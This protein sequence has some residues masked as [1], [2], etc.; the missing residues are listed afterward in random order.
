MGSN[1]NN[2]GPVGVAAPSPAPSTA[3]VTYNRP[4]S[5]LEDAANYNIRH[6]LQSKWT[7]WYRASSKSAG[8]GSGAAAKSSAKA[9]T[10]EA[11]LQCV[12]TV[13]TIEDFWGMYNNVPG[14]SRMEEN[15]D[16]MFFKEG[17]RPAW[18]DPANASGGSFT[19][20]FKGA[21]CGEF[22]WL[23]TLMLAVGSV[24]T[25]CD[26]VT[27]VFFARR[28]G[29][30]DRISLWLSSSDRE[31][32][33]QVETEWLGAL[34]EVNSEQ[35]NWGNVSFTLHKSGGHGGGER[36]RE[37]GNAN[38]SGGGY[39]SH[40]SRDNRG[41]ADGSVRRS[42]SEY[43]P[44]EGG[45]GRYSSGGGSN[46]GTGGPGGSGATGGS[47]SA[48]Y[49]SA[50]SSGAPSSRSGLRPSASADRPCSRQ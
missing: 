49:S 33:K 23:N 24:L 17:I 1:E 30:P 48:K 4:V 20:Q 7:L 9:D 36:Q 38:A 2:A 32:C 19:L 11:S 5:A 6:P 12:N 45:G 46:R 21:A 18:E 47:S 3:A 16:Y 13:D 26:K 44:R 14:I 42:G 40:G 27:G 35:L 31:L 50:S 25:H 29:R 39:S 43:Y 41:G 22:L 34:Q 28:G 10:W 8:G 15:S 37:G